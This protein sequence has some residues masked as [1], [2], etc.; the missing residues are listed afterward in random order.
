MKIIFSPAKTFDL[1]NPIDKDWVIHS[2]T[3]KIVEILK[4]QSSDSLKKLLK[5]SDKLV[6]ENLSYIAGFDARTSYTA[7]NIY[8]GMAYKSLD[9]MSLDASS[10]EYLNDHLLILSALYG[11]I[12]ADT[13][14]MPYRLD[15]TSALRVYNYIVGIY[16]DENIFND[17]I[18]KK[19]V[20]ISLK[21]FWTP[22]YNASIDK[23]ET[24][25]NLAS[26]EFSDL[27][28]TSR[29]KWYDVDFF[30]LKN[31][32]KKRHSTISKKGRGRLLR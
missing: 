2:N 9:V 28:D 23:D 5:I 12:P 22:L 24:I 14:V 32:V 19:M 7:I 25:I 10:R 13:C 16:D 1:S 3:A 17:I 20:D 30:E 18:N 21:K 4:S 29:Y 8:D 15:F 6:D 26:N 27:F 31:G 11:V